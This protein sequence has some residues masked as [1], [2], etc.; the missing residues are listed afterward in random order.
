MGIIHFILGLVLLTLGRKLFWLFVGCV[1]FVA[2]F[3]Y[4]Q[5]IFDAQSDLVIL[6]I[7]TI[8]GLIAAL[9]AVFL[10]RVAIALAGF[11]AGGQITLDIMGMFGLETGQVIWLP[12]L[13]GGIVG[14]VLLFLV[15]D[16]ALIIISSIVGAGLIVQV[17]VF[18]PWLE[19]MLF[20]A[21]II[22]GAIFQARLL[23]KKPES[24]KEG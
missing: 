19:R 5:Q 4:A 10:Q 12:Y 1:G 7:A 18:G 15:F 8:A 20:F 24:E 2:G 23:R 21:L 11:M 17:T 6:A 14:A 9:I 22:L 3:T 13:I 16:W